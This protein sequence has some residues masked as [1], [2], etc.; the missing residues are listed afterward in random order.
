MPSVRSLLTACVLVALCACGDDATGG[1]ADAGLGVGADGS[2]GGASAE[3]LDLEGPWESFA[4]RPCPPDS[5]LTWENFGASHLL[6]HCTGCHGRGRIGDE[7]SG[8][9]MDIT[10]DDPPSVR[11]HADRIW[12]RAAD[13]NDTMPPVGGPDA[14]QRRLFGEWIACDAPTR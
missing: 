11:E 10:F 7:R 8:A 14:E 13:Q 12:A 6:A 2:G 1:D 5:I 3:P 4:Q 9:P